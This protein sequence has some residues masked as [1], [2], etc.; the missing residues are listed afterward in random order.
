MS[1]TRQYFTIEEA[2]GMI[3]AL[4]RTFGRMMQLHAQ[5]R[6]TFGALQETGN[7]PSGDDF[8]VAPEGVSPHVVQQ[9]ASLKT[10][11][12]ALREDLLTLHRRG[13]IVKSVETG[14][15]DWYARSDGRDVLLCW[16]LGEKEVS[17]WHE[18]DAGFDARKSIEDLHA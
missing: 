2:N 8:E 12:E 6:E 16:K 3:P 14:L 1:E 18:I 17:Y 11:I 13:C 5:I 7:A 4:E 9:L 15:V 10:L